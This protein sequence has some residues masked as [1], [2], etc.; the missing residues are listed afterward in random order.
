MTM[1]PKPFAEPVPIVSPQDVPYPGTLRV[2]VDATDTDRRIFNARQTIPVAR[3]GL[4]T[5]LYPKWLPGYHSPEAPI[6][7][8][9]GLVITAGGERLAW[10][11]D[12]VEVHA[13]HIDVP[14]G[15]DEIE[16]EFQFLSPTSSAQGRV[17]VTPA[18]LNLQW[19]TVLLYP[20]GYYSRQIT[21]EAGVT[22][23]PEWQFGCALA[24]ASVSG[25]TTLF[26]PVSLDVLVDSPMFAGR[27]FRRVELDARGP[28]RM[29]IV[30]DRADQLAFTDDQV[31]PHRALV[32]EADL[33]FGAR[34][35]DHYDFLLALSDEL[36]GIGVEHHRSS[37]TATVPNY[38][39]DWE[40]SAPKRDTIAH[41]YTHSWNGKFRRG[42]DSWTPTF[43][44]PIRNSLM[45]VYEGQTQYWGQVLAA[46]SGLWTPEMAI[47]AIA[48]TAASYDIRRGRNWRPMSDTTRDP[49]IA[50][51]A[52]LPWA[53]W[54]RSE[55]YYS[56]GQLV[57][58]E[59]DTM[60]REFSDDVRS[61]DDFAAS[62]FGMDDGSY[63]T[64]PYDFAEVVATLD[65]LAAHDWAGFLT[66]KLE[67]KGGGAPLGGVE[68]GGYRL[69]Y[70]DT[71]TDYG[72]RSDAAMG[73]LNLMFSIGLTVSSDGVLNEVIWGSPAFDA[74]LVAGASLLAVNGQDY[75]PDGLKRAI[76]GAADGEPLLL[77]VKDGKRHRTVDIA[78]THGLRYPHFEP[79]AE[80]RRLDRIL[81]P[82]R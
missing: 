38:F 52:P 63:V 69:V 27:H 30:A 44:K 11:R 73:S 67:R 33:L 66:E 81:A 35:Y 53:S 51:R 9:A 74:R 47:G 48:Q 26:E 49:I 22:L 80:V 36:G 19:N 58:L 45:W 29:N 77:I 61:L 21:V 6:E 24:V 72:A 57:W 54:Q 70:R 79:I 18:M 15:T 1:F 59:I 12:P 5:L 62:F 46:R 8:F 76:A 25:D 41:E 71:P 2:Q 39:T 37:E 42:A 20:A 31:A 75:T 23:P 65:E 43:E 16:A 55:D 14:D 17:V 3:A 56:E 10:R 64:R 68:R 28:V 60:I 4:T 34:H 78:Y 82:R 13:F 50:A 7:L 32:A 40:G